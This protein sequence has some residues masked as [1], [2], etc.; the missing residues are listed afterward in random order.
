MA[1]FL[2]DEVL[3]HEVSIITGMQIIENMDK[4]KYNVIPIYVNKEGKWLTGNSL[5]EFKNYK[6]NNL[7]MHKK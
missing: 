2:V 4:T 3:K 5:M 7:K 1:V 6:E